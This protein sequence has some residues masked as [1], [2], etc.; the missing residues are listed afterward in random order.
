VHALKRFI[1]RKLVFTGAN[2]P[3][4]ELGFVEGLN[5]IWGASNAGKSF[6]VKALDFMSGA[7]STLPKITELEG[8]ERCWLELDLPLSGRLT[9]A[10]ALS[11]GGFALY[12][13]E[14]DSA[15]EG[16]PARTLA[17]AHSS[18]AE[19]LSSFLLAELGIGEKKIAK[20]LNGQPSPFTFRH[21]APYVYTE[22]TD[23]MAEWSPIQIAP[24]SGDTFDKNVLKFILTGVDDSAVI[25]T[26]SRGEQQTLNFGKLEI[27]D[28]LLAA[29]IDELKQLFPEDDID[30]LDLDAQN[31]TLSNTISGLQKTLENRQSH[32]DYLRRERR[33]VMNEREAA[34][35]R[36]AEIALTLDRF[37]LLADVYDSDVIRLESLEEGAAALLAGA[38]RPC[39]LC[40]A[41]PEH[42]HTSHGYEEV[43]RAQRAVRA[44]IAKIGT[45]RFDLAKA[46]NSLQAE[47]TSLSG[48]ISRLSDALGEIETQIKQAQPLEAES[49]GAYEE[50]DLARQRVRD[51]LALR[52]RME[53][54]RNRRIAL[55]RFRPS[56]T[57][58]DSI[59][60]G[61]SG[62]VGHEFAQTVQSVLHAWHF[63]GSPTVSFDDKTHDILIDGKDRRGNGKGVRA[64]MNA[65][66]KIGVLLYCRSKDL[67]H[68]GVV[69]LDS[70]LL[71]YR[72]PHTSRHGS[73][74]D[75]EARVKATGL[76]EHFYRFLLDKA[77][78]SQF[79][80][81]ENDAPPFDLGAKAKVTIFSGPQGAAG[82]RGLL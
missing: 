4:V 51:G 78:D 33:A 15:L 3:P 79:I 20:N 25:P 48:R 67:P 64:L 54:L 38:G 26:K 22:E 61:I 37:S 73:L 18:R 28:E 1:F 23:M 49:R 34:Q 27:V 21:F 9:F 13:G 19:S 39:P 80:I 46:T 2:K 82:R 40:G 65:A 11:G 36:S 14:V 42:Q 52:R 53:S 45:E 44:E 16:I 70:P 30:T 72:D 69:V 66:F 5:V 75:D 60:V 57:P 35:N 24:Q 10:R 12:D 59:S 43:E 50:L 47:Q 63:P 41:A 74:S 31:E 55:E 8:F 17:A 32:L 77:E 68:P 29:A 62:P 81:V 76:K 71:A 56:S 7:G 58:R 6:T